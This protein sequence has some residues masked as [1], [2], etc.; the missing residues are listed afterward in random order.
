M[1]GIRPPRTTAPPA[2]QR[3]A[4]SRGNLTAMTRSFPEAMRLMRSRDPQRREDGFHQLLPHA[5]EHLDELIEQFDHEQDDHRLRCWLLELVAA[6]ASPAALPT[7]AAQL[8]GP[9][10]ALRA[11]AAVG[12]SKLNTPEARTLLRQA[13]VNGTI[14]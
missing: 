7:F 10:E 11:W 2:H 12:L 3:N 1:T 6:A 8:N 9:D 13:R 4:A 5:P 14:T